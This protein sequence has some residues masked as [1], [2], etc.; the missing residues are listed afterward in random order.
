MS[1]SRLRMHTTNGH[2]WAL[3]VFHDDSRGQYGIVYSFN[4]GGRDI[5]AVNYTDFQPV[6]AEQTFFVPSFDVLRIDPIS[7]SSSA[8]DRQDATFRVTA[9]PTC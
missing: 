5:L 7:A 3:T 6:S 9:R 4:T 2:A 8:A 1:L